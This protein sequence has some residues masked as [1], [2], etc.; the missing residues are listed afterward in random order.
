M[1]VFDS[2]TSTQWKRKLYLIFSRL[3][4]AGFLFTYA[5]LYA[6]Q[7][8][9]IGKLVLGGV[10]LAV[11][12]YGSYNITA[13]EEPG[14]THPVILTIP[15]GATF[16]QV[17]DSL[18][19]YHLLTNKQWFLLLGRITGK[20]GAIRAGRFAI[21]DSLSD[22][23]LLQYLVAARPAQVKVTLNE[24][25]LAEQMASIL[26]RK[27]GIDSSRFVNLVYDSSFS[28]QLAPE[29]PNLEGYLLPET[30]FFEWKTP[31]EDIISYL[32]RQ[33]LKIFEAD[34]VKEQLKRLRMTRRQI[35]ILASII[36]G[37]AMVDSERVYIS[38]VYHNRLRKGWRLQAD[39]TIQFAI[40]GPPRRLL[41]KD[42]DIDSPY[43]TYKYRGLPPGP[44]NNPG[45]KSILAAL[46]PKKT[47]YLYMVAVGDGSHKFTRTLR[48]HNYWHQKFNE[49]RR[50]VR[51]KQRRRLK[52][53]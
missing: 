46:F 1:S 13:L 24:G 3:G 11:L 6:I 39:P 35:I 16:R 33:T 47:N 53:H 23:E 12:L 10:I 26:H 20:Q 9:R 2:S 42:L 31:E 30:Y 50:R 34:S 52:N 29:T 49:V 25:I 38:S 22:W 40:P 45:K 19:H 15:N 32:V 37:E 5:I 8:T 28:H 27:L 18:E 43:N 51:W 17:A 4:F 36:E 7:Y 21:P 44:I 41:K 14:P 48:E